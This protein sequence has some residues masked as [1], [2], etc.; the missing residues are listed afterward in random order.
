MKNQTE[1]KN[2]WQ[3]F[4]KEK[5]ITATNYSAWAFGDSKQMT[6]ELAE[7]VIKGY[8]T[9]T[10]SAYDLYETGEKIP[11]VGEYNIILDGNHQAA[12]ITQTEV[13]EVVPFNLVSAEH[14]Y[15]EGEGDRTLSYWRK[16]HEDFFKREYTDANKIF[17]EDIPCLC[18]VFKVVYI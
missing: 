13:V 6:D 14:A 4:V 18:E 5:N 16:V 1:I 7:L 9:A 12:C 3:Q 17:S 11:E 8:K 10:T 15:H 2:Y